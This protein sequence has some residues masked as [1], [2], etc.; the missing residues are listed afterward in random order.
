MMVKFNIGGVVQFVTIML[1]ITFM[2]KL[3][4]QIIAHR[5]GLI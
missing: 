1:R 3:I 5:A 2:D 4:L